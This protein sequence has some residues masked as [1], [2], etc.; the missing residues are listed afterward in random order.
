[1]TN[2]KSISS[3]TPPRIKSAVW[4]CGNVPHLYENGEWIP[5]ISS[6]ECKKQQEEAAAEIAELKKQLKAAQ[7][8]I[9][10]LNKQLKEAKDE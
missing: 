3:P 5:Y 6:K 8:K 1:M 9:T 7:S 10:S 4:M 2:F